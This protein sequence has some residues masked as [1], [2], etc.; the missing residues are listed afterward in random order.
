MKRVGFWFRGGWLKSD[1][2]VLNTFDGGGPAGVK[3]F[4]EDGGGPAGVV[5]GLAANV[6]KPLALLVR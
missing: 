6:P 3:E 1:S 5:D 2:E 4:V